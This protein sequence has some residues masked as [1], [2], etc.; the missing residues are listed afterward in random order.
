MKARQHTW[1]TALNTT[2]IPWS[3]HAGSIH[4]GHV[5]HLPVTDAMAEGSV[6]QRA[7]ASC[8]AA[9]T[10]GGLRDTMRLVIKRVFIRMMVCWVTAAPQMHPQKI[11]AFSVLCPSFNLSHY[12]ELGLFDAIIASQKNTSNLAAV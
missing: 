7:G 6:A 8:M 11:G 10:G 3:C 4:Q 5:T 1:R 2:L 9:L 12:L